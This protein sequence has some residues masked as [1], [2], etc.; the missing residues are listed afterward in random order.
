MF[1]MTDTHGDLFERRQSWRL[2]LS[3]AVAMAFALSAALPASAQ[4]SRPAEI[5]SRQITFP[6]SFSGPADTLIALIGREAGGLV[7]YSSR[8]MPPRDVHV[9]AGRHSVVSCLDAIFGR[10][11]VRYVC[12]GEKIVVAADSV[13]TRVVSGFCRDALTGEAL[14]GAYVADTV[15]GRVTATNEYGFFS[16]SVPTGK[17]P[18]R[19]SYVGYTQSARVVRMT[20]DTVVELRLK[21]HAMLPTVDIKATAEPE[22][23]L[24]RTGFVALPMEQ[25]KTMPTLMGEPDIG[26]ALQQ[27]PGVQS[28]SEGFGGMSVRGGGQDQNMVYLDDAPLYNANHMLGLFSVFNSEAVNKSV[29]LKSGFPARYGG[30]MSSVLDIKTIDGNMEQFEGCAN[31]GLVSSSLMAQGPMK[32]G[33]SSFLFSARRSYF[34][35]ILYHLQNEDN[36]Y[37]YLFYDF[38]GKFNW[39][40]TSR[41]RLRLSLF[42]CRDRLNDDSNLN[43]ISLSYGEDETRK[44]TTSDETQRTWGTALGS[45]RWSCAIGSKVFC[46]TTLWSSLY[47]SR[48]S[49]RYDVGA[50]GFHGYLGNRYSNSIYDIG[51]RADVSIYP[52]TPALGKIR[53]GGWFARKEYRPVIRSYSDNEGDDVQYQGNE[54]IARCDIHAYYEE[55]WQRGPL[56]LMAGLHL[57]ID[58]RKGDT[59][60]IIPEPRLLAGWSASE[61]L[62]LKVGGSLTSQNTYQVKVMNVATPADYWL[63]VPDGEK[64]QKTWQISVAAE[65]KFVSDLSLEIEA[66]RKKMKDMATNKSQTLSLITTEKDWNSI[67][68]SGNGYAHGIEFFLHRRKGRVTGWV[69]YSLSKSRSRYDDV[70]DGHFMPSDNDRLHSVKVFTTVKVSPRADIAVSWSYGSGSPY[71]L[72]TQHYSLPGTDGTFAVPAKRNAMRMPPNHQLNLGCNMNFGD[73]RAGSSLSFGV[74]NVYGRKNPMFI[75][76]RPDDTSKLPTFRLK[77]FS[78]IAFPCPYI[79]YSIHF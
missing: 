40:I 15:L 49:Q 27:T 32:L 51:L 1:Q 46:N 33:R 35:A 20:A 29:L 57:T 39:Q 41:S 31:V 45:L 14:I 25:V 38:H 11:N 10:Y 53:V 3:L 48:N 65:W 56:W 67:Y 43:T 21:P 36:S 30:R 28:G 44:L 6:T 71:S 4:K 2:F 16:L 7:A 47:Q 68:T 59:P 22:A 74:Y 17:V 26:N 8:V 63:P 73:R 23:E 52:S 69:G 61:R 72:P 9:R 24:G 19:A 54:R 5:L 34:D 55:S 18:L 58:Q 12:H 50:D 79:K 78:L 64:D 75:Y 60:N 66:Y 70:N 13:K 62:R 76:W 77:Q 37:S 42:F